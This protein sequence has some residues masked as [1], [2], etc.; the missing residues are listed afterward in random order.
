[1]TGGGSASG[2]GVAG[3]EGGSSGTGGGGSVEGVVGC[4]VAGS[5][6]LLLLLAVLSRAVKGRRRAAVA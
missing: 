6:E 3:G 2:G 5:P 1:M 4:S